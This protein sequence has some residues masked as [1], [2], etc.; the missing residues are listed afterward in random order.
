MSET[1]LASIDQGH[2]APCLQ[3]P[4]LSSGKLFGAFE[5]SKSFLVQFQLAGIKARKSWWPMS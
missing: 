3:K 5:R 1:A 4:D 2:H